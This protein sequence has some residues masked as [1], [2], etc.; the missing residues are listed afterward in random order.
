M[1]ARYIIIIALITAVI[2][3]YIGTAFLL[4]P[5]AINKQS[6][7]IRLQSDWNSHPG[8]IIYEVTNVWTKTD[9]LA[10]LDPQTRL[11]LSKQANVDQV[12]SVHNKSYI[13][14]HH[15]N[16][17]C[18]DLWEP[19]YARFGADTIRHQVEYVLGIQKSLD[20]NKNQ[21]VPLKGKIGDQEHA[22]QI[23]SGYSQFIPICT[24]NELTSFDY[25]VKIND[26]SVGFDVYFVPSIEQQKNFDEGNG[27][28]EHYTNG[29]CEG[30]NYVR[31]SGTCNNV[32]KSA[33][34]LIAVP[35]S[36]TLP[37]TKIEVWLYEK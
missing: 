3:Y 31:F 17:N 23:R 15:G 24:Q 26:E 6:F 20:P 11:D 18:H 12:R 35:D 28:F 2:S 9:E 4:Q 21:Y 36:L 10:P 16:T 34:L 14:V 33:G 27:L 5:Q 32:G 1:R 13:M 37:L 29:Q 19:H 22:S 8:N 7:Y 30:K 25:S